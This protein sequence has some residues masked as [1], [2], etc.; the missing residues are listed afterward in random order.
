MW[1]K[2]NIHAHTSLSDGD[3]PPAE[4]VAWY[5]DHDFDFL[6]ITD[7][8]V[9]TVAA[10][11]RLVLV[12]GTEITLMDE[13]K[14]VHVNALGVRAMPALPGWHGSIVRT[15]QAAVGAAHAVGGLAMI[16]HPNFHWAF[17]A[18]E[19]AQVT[20]WALLEIMNTSTDCNSFGG[21]G[22]PPVQIWA[23]SRCWPGRT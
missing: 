12:P 16:N 19:M 17:G 3:A 4:V 21:G 22:H 18:A 5:A 2:G 20:G 15:L 14:P 6:A 23:G 10:S 8:N 1:L 13:G 7:H 11:D 9:L